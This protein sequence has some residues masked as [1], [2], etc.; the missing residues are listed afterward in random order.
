MR[1]EVQYV[2]ICKLEKSSPRRIILTEIN[3]CIFIYICFFFI[4]YTIQINTVTISKHCIWME[5]KINKC[6][7]LCCFSFL[8]LLYNFCKGG[9]L[10]SVQ[11][12]QFR[13]SR[14]SSHQKF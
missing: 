12:M 11:K 13:E 9:S 6:S 5:C 10:L 14:K 8:Q 2:H 7:D 4:K 3:C 1:S